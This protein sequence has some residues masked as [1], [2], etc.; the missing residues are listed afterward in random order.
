ML[1]VSGYVVVWCM[2]M[3]LVKI[4]GKVCEVMIEEGMCVEEG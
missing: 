1:D 2:V 3:V 4:I